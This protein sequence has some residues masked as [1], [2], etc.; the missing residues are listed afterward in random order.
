MSRSLRW[1]LVLIV[2]AVGSRAVG[3]Q[4]QALPPPILLITNSAASNPYG[5]YLGEILRAEGLNQFATK[6]LAAVTSTDLSSAELVLLAE[7][8]LTSTQAGLLSNYVAGGGRLVAMRPDSRLAPVL[9]LTP[10]GSSTSEGYFAINS[11]TTFAD[12]FPTTTLP[13]HGQATNYTVPG[14]ATVLATLYSNATT[15]TAFPAV[16]KWGRTA[17]WTYD[18]ARSIVYTRQGNPANASDR[19]GQPPFRTEDTFY[20]AI[21]LD[22]VGTPF[23]DVQM[24]MLGRTI[25]DL[26]ADA[27]PVPRLWYFP[28]SNRTLMIVTSDSHANPQSYFDAVA[29]S[30]E[31]R[32]GNVSFYI[33]NGSDPSPAQVATW[34]AHGHEVGMHPAGYQYSR[35]IDAA[36]LAA[37]DYFTGAGDG[38]PSPTT[39]IHQVEWQGWVDAAKVEASY[40]IGLDTSF[41]TWG[42]AVT[43]AD[44][45]Q[46]HGYINGSGLPMRFID[47]TGAVVPVYQQV[48][49]LIDEQLVISDFSE[50]LPTDQA[51]AVSRQ[52]IDDSQAGSYSAITTQFHVD[53]FQ[54]GEVNP[55]ALGTMDYARGLGIPMWTAE[56]WLN[57]NTA[58]ATTT[59]TGLSWAGGAKQLSFTVGVP[60]GSEPQSVA[61]PGSYNGFGLTSVVLDGATVSTITQAITGRDTSFL[62]VT[63]GT[64]TVVATYTTPIPPPEH[65][66]IA[67]ADTAN[68]TEAHTV[69][70]PVLANDHDADGDALT[71][72]ST[73][74]DAGAVI[75][76]NADQTISY[77]PNAGT[78]G[79]DTFGYTISDGRGGTAT[80]SVT[81]SVTCLNGQ[82]QQAT[83]TDFGASCAVPTNAIVSNVGNG[84]VRLAGTQGDEYNQA[85]LDAGKWVAGTWSGGT[86]APSPSGGILSVANA[87]GA[88]VRSVS[89]VPITTLES[90][91]RFSTLPWEHVGWSSL[92]FSGGYAI[93]STY[94][95]TT[96]LF[97]RTSLDG[98]T[99][100]QTSLGPI[101]TG[102]HTYRVERQ[103][104]SPSSNI[105]SYY[106]DGVLRAQH[107]VG[108]LPPMYVYQS[109]SGGTAQTLDI[110]R[111]WI[112]PTYV[113]AGTYQSC[114]LDIGHTLSSWT[115]ADWRATVPSGTTLRLRTRTSTDAATWSGWSAPLT[116]SGQ[117]VTSPAGRY[118]QYLAE[119]TT[120]DPNQSAVLDS[121][122]VHFADSSIPQEHAPIAVSDA[123]S[124]SEGAA[125]TVSVLSNDSD[126][127]GDALSVVST[128]QGAK[129]GVAINADFSVT[130]TPNPAACGTD[131]FTYTISDGRGKIAS[132]SVSVNVACVSGRVTQATVVD[133]GPTCSVSSNTQVSW[134]GDGEVRLAGLQ[135]DEFTGSTLDPSLWVAG[136]WSGATYTP[137]LNNGILSIADA[138]GAFVRSA[139]SMPVTAF[140]AS[141][142]FAGLPWQHV[143][144]ASL[145]FSGGYA[146]FSTYNTGT[147][148]FARTNS[149]SGEQQTDLGPIPS[150]F[151]TYRID[152]QTPAPGS[153]VVSYYVD[154][155]LVAQHT[156]GTLGSMYVYVSHNGGATQTLDVDRVSTYPSY[157]SAGTFQ[158]C[159]MD[160]GTSAFD[161]TTATW[162]ATVPVGTT[163]QLS[164]RT[165]V[166]GVEWSP[167]SPVAGNG[168]NIGS[169]AGRYLQYL[170]QLTTTDPTLS[171]VVDSVT[172]GLRL[173]N[174]DATPPVLSNIAVSNIT[175][176]SAIVSWT[177]DEAATTT[178]QFGQT[179]AYGFE[180]STSAL[181]TSHTQLLTGLTAGTTNHFRVISKDSAG[182]ES[183]SA[184]G[185]FVTLQ[186]TLSINSISVTEG[187]TGSAPAAFTVTLSAPSNQTVTV[188]Y[189]TAPGT[190]ATP[191][192]YASTSG[193]LTFAPGITSLPINVNIVGD[194]L[195][196]A[197]ETFFVNL[198]VPTNAAITTAQGV[199]TIVDNDPLP[200]LSINNVSLTEGNSGT[201]TATFTVTM[202]AAS[203]QTVSVAFATADGTATAGSDYVAK[204]GTLTFAPGS[205]SQSIAVTVNGDTALEPNETF[206]VNL[207]SPVAVTIATGQGTGTIL[208]NDPPVIA[209][210]NASVTEG[211]SGTVNMVFTVT[212][213]Q[214]TTSTVTVGY[215]T[216]NGTATAGS[217]YVAKSGTLTFTPGT[218]SASVTVAVN[219][220]TLIEAD[221]TFVVNLSGPSN[222]TI[223]TAQGVG[224]IIDNEAKPALSIND[225]SVTE[226]NTGTSTASFT[227]R[228][229]AASTQTV[230]VNYATSDG[231][232]TAGSD[233][234]AKS[235]TLTFAPGTTT[236]T[237]AVVVNGDT[238]LEPNETFVVTLTNPANATISDSV[239]TGTI[240][241]NDPP[242]IAID[243]VSVSE[244]NS[245]TVNAAFTV[246]LSQPTTSTVTVSYA[247]ANGTATA[248]SDYVAKSG[249]L[250]IPAGATS[251][252][253]SV[254]VNGDASYEPDETF[255]V[256]LSSP[257]NATIAVAQGIGTI[258]NDDPQ[259]AL[260][261]NNVNVTE[262]NS[263]T[264]NATFT[265]TLSASSYQTVTV[266]Y[267]TAN[268]TATAGSDYVAKSGT[269]TFAPGVTTQT[270]AVAVNGDTVLEPNETFVVNL[271]SPGNAT[272]ATAQGTG[273]ILNDDAP[274]LSINNVSVAEGNS[275]TVNATFTVTLASPTTNT[276][277]VTY[278]TA[279]GTAA[280]GSDYV[281]KSGTLTIPG[282]TTST[283]LSV[284]VNGDSAFEQDETFVVNLS[285]ATNATITTAQGVATILNDDTQPSLSVNSVSVTEG[286]TSG[287]AATFTA[288]LSAP[289]FQTVTVNYATANGSATAGSDYTAT[290]ATLTFDPGTTSRTF[291][292]TTLGDTTPEADETF[293][294]NLS[295][296]TNATISGAQ[297]T[298]TI[299]DNDG[300]IAVAAPNT[301]VTWTVNS[302]Q[303]I[304]W[305]N[306]LGSSA[307]VRVELSRDGG[308]TWSVL[309]ASV[310]NSSATGGSFSWTVTTPTT[311]S[312]RVRVTWLGNDRVTDSSNVNFTIAVPSITLTSP[313]GGNF[314]L[315]GSNATI[316]W[317][318]TLPS[319][320]NVKIELSTN[321]GA[322]YSIVVA[323][324]TP[325]D[326]SQTVAVQTAW[327]SSQVRIRITSLTD[328]TVSD[329]SNS[330]FI[331]L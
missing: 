246:T 243:N 42:P 227:V 132:S 55:W 237:I 141:A 4:S 126:P 170:L 72:V 143:G 80:A 138:N 208:N 171:P 167:W 331:I 52:L 288:S 301:A 299:L 232:A 49:S 283:T 215:A 289:S 192:D 179:R 191:A 92:N 136:T 252:T 69:T 144:W 137:V 266:A 81:V 296:P 163:L 236:Q 79:A 44:G 127:D 294:V 223:G 255:V 323:A 226:G 122:T 207:T 218:T 297:G 61:L 112:Y 304:T 67:T 156:V 173:T 151:H 186:P 221:E 57:Y 121:V 96:T 285:G 216:A 3:I 263:G 149:G 166:D 259:P 9:G 37:E 280:A 111:L 93:F 265:V 33:Y 87:N 317:S 238:L 22:K 201:S 324:S 168:E 97:A 257:G 279:N 6:D 7:T 217:D 219:G 235:G 1:L 26:L 71:V 254:V 140:E 176:S 59:M 70:I 105:V 134:A 106:V 325:N 38:L 327:R 94:N 298:G 277:T 165:S 36:F 29:S 229:S 25:S 125:V 231:T 190:A 32:G 148:L 302:V 19:D 47:Q 46:A 73:S 183:D 177:T 45:H 158:S 60:T 54:F 83:V 196:E 174:V 40:G 233:Y 264:S 139:G 178:V 311:T 12:G 172:M 290:S 115:T 20:N 320:D 230:T 18:L 253:L 116:S 35:S 15:A 68:V 293:L 17:T 256:N 164:T 274:G 98:S 245:G 249:T 185:S 159:A 145:D 204:S 89:S 100:Q 212:L 154:G 181:V 53:Y 30:V 74:S 303:T 184:D 199:G 224:T 284:V 75:T 162:N 51:L 234:V 28:G 113:S 119:F 133:F 27:L 152:R 211:N 318:S 267:A 240:L 328:G 272:I 309:A 88:Y 109:H 23:A 182:N 213:S 91:V 189:A 157:Q 175:S 203:G 135:A 282:G 248:G 99:E 242:A 103:V 244:G 193:T 84:E 312:A 306:N 161:W 300:T 330:N 313:N 188:A 194:T 82:V 104:V 260:S 220:D 251:T 286:N 101:P 5:A 200:T 295:S 228:L 118:L 271:T 129:G 281:A 123:A 41:Y 11:A 195:S 142:R 34:R 43:Y 108:A 268:G 270:I 278:A 225:A 287:V 10:A 120:S 269:L 31:T 24:R 153:D 308:S 261:I 114:T 169:P 86:Y 150:G 198:S 202:S 209:I 131:T 239:G 197:N 307:T 65:A 276:V 292:V 247:T 39:R 85:T 48:T 107:T 310:Q 273:T 315:S 2:T 62:T 250:T 90:S 21:D 305:T 258:V 321:G 66:P 78:C 95:T 58:R 322:T 130:Y 50:H 110:D 155:V 210:G 222:A 8:A 16:V 214:P 56:R 262:G 128:T 319:T 329:A 124:T 64:H 146:V 326:G 14:G 117:D 205:V 206:V 160:G 180:T 314:W 63:P 102:F 187:D 275:G 76:I 77:S 291:T 241:N 147:N 316:T 13:F